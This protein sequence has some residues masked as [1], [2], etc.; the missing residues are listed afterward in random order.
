[1]LPTE[2]N[3]NKSDG[4]LNLIVRKEKKKEI[5]QAELST[6]C[7]TTPGQAEG[8]QINPDSHWENILWY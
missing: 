1:M 7:K 2:T 3:G 5:K 6:F 8:L 4:C